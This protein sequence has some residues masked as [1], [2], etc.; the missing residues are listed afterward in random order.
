MAFFMGKLKTNW[1][2]KTASVRTVKA[3]VGLRYFHA[4]FLFMGPRQSLS[5]R[6]L[7]KTSAKVSSKRRVAYGN[8]L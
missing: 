1:A 3:I 2:W 4:L 5:Q 6:T 7:L 8:Y